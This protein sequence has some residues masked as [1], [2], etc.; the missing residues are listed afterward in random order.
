MTCKQKKQD[1]KVTSQKLKTYVN[2]K[3]CKQ[4]DKAEDSSKKKKKQE[5]NPQRC[6]IRMSEHDL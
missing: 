3:V 2:F 5:K 6:I 4:K 1:I